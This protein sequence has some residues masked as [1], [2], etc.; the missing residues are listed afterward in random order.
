MIIE[1]IETFD[2]EAGDLLFKT[3]KGRPYKNFPEI[4]QNVFKKYTSKPISINSLRHSY[5]TQTRGRWR[6]LSAVTTPSKRPSS[7][8]Q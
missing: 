5:L 3:N 1:Y 6:V 4:V 8:M 2:L 7:K